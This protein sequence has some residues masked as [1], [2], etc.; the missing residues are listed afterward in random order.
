MPLRPG[1]PD[2]PTRFINVDLMHHIGRRMEPYDGE[3][4]VSQIKI[5]A[6]GTLTLPSLKD[7]ITL[8][9]RIPSPTAPDETTALT[10]YDMRLHRDDVPAL[11]AALQWAIAGPLGRMAIEQEHGIDTTVGSERDGD[12]AT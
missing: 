9:E 5:W 11:I 7:Y 6:P 2:D 12:A 3:R 10:T 1:I 8:E 4:T